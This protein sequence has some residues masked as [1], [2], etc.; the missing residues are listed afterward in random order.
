MA[1]LLDL[2]VL[3]GFVWIKLNSDP[4]VLGVAVVTIVVIAVAEQVYLKSSAR[5][6]AIEK[7]RLQTIIDSNI[8]EFTEKLF[9]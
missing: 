2:L 4:F 3:G 5:K 6:K 8:K 1:I 9:G 7:I